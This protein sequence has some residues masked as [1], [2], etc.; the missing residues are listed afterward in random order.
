MASNLAIC[1][2][3]RRAGDKLFLKG[4]KCRT[5]KCPMERRATTPGQHP[6]KQG[7]LKLSEYGKQLA[8]KQKVKLMYGSLEKQF[9][10]IFEIAS[11][12]K[13]I[14][15]ESLLSLLERRIDNVVFR[16]KMAYSREQARQFVVHGHI[17]V[18][19]KRVT[20]PSYIVKL[21]DVISLSGT[22]LKNKEFVEGTIDKR[23]NIGIKLPEWLELDKKER[24]GTVLRL[25]IRS[26]VAAPIEEHLIVELYSK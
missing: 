1:R 26:D 18:N 22:T 23:L 15:G 24:K 14:T 20:S 17:N 21:G 12:T 19:G 6:K 16:L 8:E 2:R 4:S 9:R 3:C 11:A 10:R 5:A 7:T 25:P 13:G